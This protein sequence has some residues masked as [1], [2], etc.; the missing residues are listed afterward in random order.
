MRFKSLSAVLSVISAALPVSPAALAAVEPVR[1]GIVD[2]QKAI[3]TVDS[4]KKA[5]SQLEKEFNSRKEALQI[6]RAH[7]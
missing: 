7:V 5:R 2:M 3:Q 6:G 4:G 1:I